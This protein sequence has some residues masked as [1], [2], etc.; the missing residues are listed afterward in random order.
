MEVISPVPEVSHETRRTD[1]VL[2]SSPPAPRSNSADI[3]GHYLLC[4]ISP[5][6]F[7]EYQARLS[8]S[9]RGL[10]GDTLPAN[11][12]VALRVW[13][14]AEE[15]EGEWRNRETLRR[16]APAHRDGW[17]AGGREEQRALLTE[18]DPSLA[19][20]SSPRVF[21]ETANSRRRPAASACQK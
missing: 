8:S 1:D 10:V 13:R 20:V 16:C 18:H 12:R 19:M 3:I 4:G 15:S 5:A 2:V 14:L 11:I 21:I 7:H 6:L 17:Q 9:H